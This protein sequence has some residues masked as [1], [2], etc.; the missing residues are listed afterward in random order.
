MAAEEA[1]TD[2]T[3]AS[4]GGPGDDLKDVRRVYVVVDDEGRVT[5]SE[6]VAVPERW[7][8][9]CRSLYPHQPE[10]T[11]PGGGDPTRPGP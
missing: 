1:A 10:A 4:C 6:T 9:A 2:D 3:C 5:G 8:A 7:C 11:R